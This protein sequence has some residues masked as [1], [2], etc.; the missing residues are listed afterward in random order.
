[1]QI[2]IY[3][4]IIPSKIMDMFHKNTSVKLGMF[5]ATPS[6]TNL[7][8][9]FRIM[10]RFGDMMQVLIPSAP[11]LEMMLTPQA[12][13]ELAKTYNDE[14][15]ELVSK[16]PERFAA[17]VAAIPMN[18][19]EAALREIDRAITELRFRGVFIQTPVYSL[20][21]DE[22][23]PPVTKALDSPEFAPIY[24]KM[25]KYNLPIWLH[26]YRVHAVSDYTSESKSRYQIW[27]VFGWPYETTAAMARL[28]FCGIMQK[29][30]SLKIIT[31]HA[32]GMV[33]FFEQRIAGG[34]GFNEMRI[35]GR[36]QVE[37]TKSPLE[38]FRMFYADTAIGGSTP[39]LMCAYA[40]F[41]AKRLLFG[42]DT[43]YDSQLG[44]RSVKKTIE[45]I[46]K[47][48]VPEGDKEA[49]F[50]LNARELL[51]LPT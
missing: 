15:A 20:L 2:D 25:V 33:P 27:H 9:R 32:G 44:F 7:D 12:A 31:H 28:V 22:N 10:D 21:K 40:F 14:L 18:D 35:G 11:P 13:T 8:T 46:E 48:D 16:Y 19:I 38:Y 3:A 4:H 42:T 36:R 34:Y 50:E 51:R 45:A 1:M 47:M 23:Q 24:E 41:G 39:G 43:P 29:Y 37:L 5:D 26:P 30:P 6:L 49:I 17:A